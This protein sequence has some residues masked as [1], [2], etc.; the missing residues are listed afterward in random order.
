VAPPPAQCRPDGTAGTNPVVPCLSKAVD[1]PSGSSAANAKTPRLPTRVSADR[2]G[3]SY[4]HRGGARDEPRQRVQPG[5]GA[6]PPPDALPVNLV[7]ID[8][9]QMALEVVGSTD[10]DPGRRR[11]TDRHHFQRSTPRSTKKTTALLGSGANAARGLSQMTV[12]DRPHSTA[13][14]KL[15]SAGRST[16]ETHHIFKPTQHPRNYGLR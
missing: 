10:A 14:T 2:P 11:R 7:Q 15:I 12:C 16:P 4:P 3:L 1:T 6:P 9:I 5:A 8:T 13:S